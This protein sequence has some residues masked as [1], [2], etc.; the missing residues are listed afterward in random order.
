MSALLILLLRQYRSEYGLLVELAAA[1]ILLLYAV[2]HLEPVLAAAETLSQRSGIPLEYLSILLKS[3]GICYLVQFGADLCR[4]VGE[5]AIAAKLELGGRIMVLVLSLP[6][7]YE[8]MD[9][10]FQ[11]I[12]Q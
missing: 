1:G 6:L 10:V 11:L 7:F 4:D 5:S 9:K 8:L 3:L 2:L 12:S